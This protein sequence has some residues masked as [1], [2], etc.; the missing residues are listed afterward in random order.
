[1]V[2]GVS[3]I[4]C[5]RLLLRDGPASSKKMRPARSGG[6]T[7]RLD[8][9]EQSQEILQIDWLMKNVHGPAGPGARDG[10]QHGDRDRREGRLPLELIV[11]LPLVH[12]R[13]P[14]VEEDEMG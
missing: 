14:Q 4:G 3:G 5:R 6:T 13:H 1:M 7:G 11:K 9:V 2:T 12:H 10:R 8:R